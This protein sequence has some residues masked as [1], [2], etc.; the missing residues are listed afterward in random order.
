MHSNNSKEKSG[1]CAIWFELLMRSAVPVHIPIHQAPS[2][3]EYNFLLVSH[4]ELLCS[5]F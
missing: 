4:S 3:M 5:S 1:P 2:Q